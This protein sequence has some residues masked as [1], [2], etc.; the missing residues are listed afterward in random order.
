VLATLGE[1]V[2]QTLTR[3][4]LSEQEHQ[5]I[6]QLQRD[7]LPPPAHVEGLEIAVTYEPAMSVIGL[8]GDFYDVIVSDTERVYLV[9]GDVTGHGS[10]AV[11]AMAELKSV[12]QQLL[13]SDA[14][15]EAVCEQADLIL[16]R[17]GILATAQI[18]EVD[19]AA[20]RLRYVN[21]GHPP[22]VLLHAGTTDLLLGAHRPLLG[23]EPALAP[24]AS[25]R[26]SSRARTMPATA[27]FDD[28]DVL[29]LYTDG[30]V[31]RRRRD[32]DA[33]IEHLRH[34]VHSANDDSM[35]D[36]VSRLLEANRV[37]A[38]NRADDDVA[39]IAVRAGGHAG[40]G[41]AA[42]E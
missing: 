35:D 11:A 36:L 6:V 18:V 7:L 42:P 14:P 10:E 41:A 3:A 28:G 16:V 19:R 40:A 13:R 8:G 24:S 27:P 30:L 38:S 34:T 23:L 12:V 1:M 17:R 25:S 5:L 26:A 4:A 31:E 2:G 20:H 37:T 29:V 15:V 21:A 39:I 32:L 22:P 33:A 9:I